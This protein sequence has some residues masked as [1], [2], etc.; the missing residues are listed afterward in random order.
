MFVGL[1]K[2]ENDFWTFTDG[3]LYNYEPRRGHFRNERCSVIVS[4]GLQDES[5]SRT[6]P[7]VCRSAPIIGMYQLYVNL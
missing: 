2:D 5:C 3:S 6:L 1:Q 7:T 4:S